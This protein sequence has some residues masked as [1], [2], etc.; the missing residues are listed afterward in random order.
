MNFDAYGLFFWVA[1]SG[2]RC[3][4][5]MLCWR[6]GIH[7]LLPRFQLLLGWEVASNLGAY[8][9]ILAFGYDSNGYTLYYFLSGAVRGVLQVMALL[10][11]ASLARVRVGS[12]VWAGALALGW[13]VLVALG[14]SPGFWAGSQLFQTGFL[15]LGLWLLLGIVIE[16]LRQSDLRLGW[17][18]AGVLLLILT[19]VAARYTFFLGQV[20]VPIDYSILRWFFQPVSVLSLALALACMRR[21]EI[22]VFLNSQEETA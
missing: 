13:M 21:L 22:P 1:G 6:G 11:V 19:D 20:F 16:V 14:D 9:A 4:L 15:H 18:V 3:L 12:W 8:P 10:E 2:L 5:I 17:N 7:R